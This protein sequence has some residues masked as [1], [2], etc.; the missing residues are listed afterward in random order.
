VTRRA[1]NDACKSRETVVAFLEIPCFFSSVIE[2]HSLLSDLANLC[3]ILGTIGGAT[4]LLKRLHRW[5][6]SQKKDS[7]P[8]CLM[9]AILAKRIK[10]LSTDI[11]TFFPAV[12][13]FQ[14]K[15]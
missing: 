14:K 3:Q 5:V 13:V 11:E 15:I 9:C 12:S 6:A 10:K 1:V 7:S 2:Y 8:G 4:W